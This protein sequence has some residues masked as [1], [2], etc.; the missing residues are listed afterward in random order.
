MKYLNKIIFF[1]VIYVLYI[2]FFN[3]YNRY[4][5]TIPIYPN[6]VVESKQLKKI[7]KTRNDEDIH[8]FY[9]TNK[10]V[11][12]AFLPYVNESENEL[13]KMLSK[14]DKLILFLKYTINRPRP[15]QVDSSI[16]P[17]NIDTA[18]TPAYP[19][20]H[21]YQA[22]LLSKQLTKKYPNK[23]KLFKTIALKCDDCR[24]KCGLHYPSDGVFSRKLV[25]LIEKNVSSL[26]Y[27]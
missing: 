21:S 17:L 20:G 24:V 6:S 23:A 7:I 3:G 18:Q 2:S 26:N 27:N 16:I 11:S 12:A 25:D 10:S 8:F 15:N 1:L 4:L 19:A 9:L 5:P 14:H 13:T 22:Y